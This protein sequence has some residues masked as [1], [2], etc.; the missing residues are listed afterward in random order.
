MWGTDKIKVIWG[1]I[2]IHRNQT[3]LKFIVIG[4]P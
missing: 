1:N 3:V 2:R 4:R